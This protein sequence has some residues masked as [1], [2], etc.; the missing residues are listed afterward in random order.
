M[1]SRSAESTR[2][3]SAVNKATLPSS[4][5]PCTPNRS[6]IPTVTPAPASTPWIWHFRFERSPTSLA[7][8]RTQWRSSLVAGGAIQASGSRPI[9]QQIRQIRGSALIFSELEDDL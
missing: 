5:W 8:C 7:R 4:W 9:A 3:R 1:T 2:A 6:L